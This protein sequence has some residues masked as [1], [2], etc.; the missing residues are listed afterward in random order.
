[1]VTT[2]SH[3]RLRHVDSG[4]WLHCP[5][6][7]RGSA[8]E[9][10]LVVRKEMLASDVYRFEGVTKEVVHDLLVAKNCVESL[11]SF[12]GVFAPKATADPSVKDFEGQ[13]EKAQY[14]RLEHVLTEMV[15]FCSQSDNDDPMTREGL[16][17]WQQQCLLCDLQFLEQAMSIIELLL[18]P[19]LKFREQ[20]GTAS[21]VRTLTR[22]AKLCQRLM[23]H[24]LRRNPTTCAYAA[25]KKRNNGQSTFVVPLQNQMSHGILAAETLREIY[26]DNADLLEKVTDDDIKGVLELIQSNEP[27][28]GRKA[29]YIEYL[30]VLCECEGKAVR[31]NQWRIANLLLSADNRKLLLDLSLK[32][33]IVYVNGDERF[34][35][36]FRGRSGTPIELAAW[37][38]APV[39]EGTSATDHADVRLYFEKT[40]HLYR[41][42]V[43]G[44]NQK[45][46]RLLQSTLSYALVE[47]VITND[48]LHRAK[49]A[50]D[51]L[52]PRLRHPLMKLSTA[53]VAIARSLYVDSYTFTDD[54]VVPHEVMT[55]VKLMRVWKN[56][57]KV[58]ASGKLSSRLTTVLPIEWNRFNGL[59]VAM[60]EFLRTHA[61]SQVAT[62]IEL[63]HCLLEV[64]KL[65]S[66]M[67][68][69][70]FVL[71]GATSTDEL[72]R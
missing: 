5:L 29:R 50:G 6:T 55:R 49:P 62:R 45:N 11:K 25:S 70:G 66:D 13:T 44:R 54:E 52:A 12:H 37:Y 57:E 60:Y 15:K 51:D 28:R 24:I 4:Y 35:P 41:L 43:T 8:G 46:T 34:F 30:M 20:Q 38:T 48:E 36:T 1:M 68:S 56:V 67:I 39:P 59:Q 42:L 18:L 64:L 7:A 71:S 69:Y 33:G 63:N 14:A 10:P 72:Q 32:D 47:A 21:C 61:A 27:G 26:L 2:G 40:V 31:P 9:R 16:P 65:L 53:F 17:Q 23:R 3:L 58:Y 22:L 19:L